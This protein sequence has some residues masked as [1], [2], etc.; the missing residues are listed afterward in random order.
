MKIDKRLLAICIALPLLVGGVAALLTRGSMQVFET[1]NKPPLSPPGWLF[2]VAWTI[3]YTLMG[4]ATYLMLTAEAEKQE[5]VRALS[6]Y[7][8][9]LIV[10]FLWPTFFFNFQWYLFSFLW[11][12]LLWVLVLITLLRY[13]NISKPAGYLL[14][15]YLVWLTFAG[16]LNFGIWL[17]N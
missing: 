17:L 15:P 10:N 8:Y 6:V 1:V 3:L 14:I 5:K 16:Y 11:L 7:I 2:P 4:I 12:V 13:Y 9:Q